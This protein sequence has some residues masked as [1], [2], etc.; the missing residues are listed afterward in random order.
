[1][2]PDAVIRGYQK[3]A[4]E[5]KMKMKVV[6][7]SQQPT[8]ALS[9]VMSTT[10]AT[11]DAVN[12]V[13]LASRMDISIDILSHAIGVDPNELGNNP[14]NPN[15]QEKLRTIV[16]LWDDVLNLT[17]DETHGRLF[18]KHKRPELQ[19]NSPL[20]YFQEGR[21]NVVRNLVFAMLEMLP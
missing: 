8:I 6:D 1:M 14:R 7:V 15:F 9:N 3:Q 17:G 19:G 2:V 5:A 21:P 12:A 18:L 13:N 10:S 20:Y 16:A 4:R 11:V